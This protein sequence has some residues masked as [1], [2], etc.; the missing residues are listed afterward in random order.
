MSLPD[1]TLYTTTWC[2]DCRRIKRRLA[3]I[4]FKYTEIDIDEHPEFVDTVVSLNDGKRRIPTILINGS[5]VRELPETA[6]LDGTWS[7]ALEANAEAG[8]R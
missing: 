4:G 6:L 2:G 8:G 7:R 3:E 1:I 5:F